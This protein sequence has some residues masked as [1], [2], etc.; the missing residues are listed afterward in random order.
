[1]YSIEEF[2]KEKTKVLKYV[3]YKKRTEREI[4]QKF[5]STIEE[6]ILNDVIEDLKENGYIS[7]NIYVQRAINE[8]IALK[9]LSL[10][11]M[12]YKL[13][14]KGVSN[15]IIDEYFYDNRDKLEEFEKQSIRKIYYKKQGLMEIEEIIQ[16]LTKKG[17]KLD[18]IKDVLSEGK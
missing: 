10:K 2:D 18:N 4:R 16:F 8:F 5:E 9:N 11:E 1:M 13:L 15:D 12:R 17:Y 3:L 14:A 7:D 6:E